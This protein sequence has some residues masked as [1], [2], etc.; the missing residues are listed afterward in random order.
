MRKF[1]TKKRIVWTILIVAV[2]GG[3]GYVIFG[4]GGKT[5]KI[6]TDTVK[7]QELKRTV[8]S[9]GQVT[10]ATDLGLSFKVGGIL[11]NLY[12]KV[13]DKVKAGQVLAVLDQKDQLA[14]LTQSRGALAQAQANYEKVMAGASSEDIAVAQRAVD[15]AQVTLDNAKSA[16]QNTKAQQDVLASNAYSAMLN[17][18]LSAVASNTNVSTPTLT[19]SGAYIGMQPGQYIITVYNSGNGP[20]FTASG[21]ETGDGA[22]KSSGPETLGKLGLFVQFSTTAVAGGDSWTIAIPNLKAANYVT[23]YNVYQAALQTQKVQVD[24]AL[25]VLESA[26]IALS[27]AEAQLALKKIQARPADIASAQAQILSAQG[28]AQTAQAALENTILRAPASG[29]ITSVD[30]KLGEQATALKEVI[31]LQDVENLHVES[32]VSEA[33]IANLKVSQSVDMTLDALGPDRHFTASLEQIDPASTVISGVVNYKVTV[34]LSKNEEIKPGMTANLTILVAEKQG[35][36]VVPARAVIDKGG[37]K[38]VVRLI[39]DSKKRTYAETA[40]QTGL[41]A[42]GGLVEILSG[43]SEGQAVVTFINK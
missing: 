3:I 34:S 33:N 23:N 6:L 42:D 41:E 40:V 15:A 25:N 43:L 31:V 38:K 37:G 10:S 28:Q 30:I 5:G 29:T 19:I 13:G 35:V 21:L 1:F 16:L 32:N 27:Q 22:V 4:R 39:T 14:S 36:L 20:R 12:V 7:R 2:L 26:R 24:S 18:T 17:S 9:T 11:Q 8:L